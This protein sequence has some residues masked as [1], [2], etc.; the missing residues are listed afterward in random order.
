MK[1]R[2]IFFSILMMIVVMSLCACSSGKEG[3][4]KA[5]T[6]VLLIVL[7]IGTSLITAFLTYKSKTGAG[8]DNKQTEI[9]HDKKE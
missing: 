9:P 3:A 4:S 2:L 8:K 6:A 1:R 7:F 5:L